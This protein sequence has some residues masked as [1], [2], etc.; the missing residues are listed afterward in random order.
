MSGFSRI[1]KAEGI[2]HFLALVKMMQNICLPIIQQNGGELVKIVGDNIFAIFT[3]ASLVRVTSQC[4]LL[5]L[6]LLTKIYCK[7]RL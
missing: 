7:C 4:V 6:L 3:S 1:S 5:L 2:L